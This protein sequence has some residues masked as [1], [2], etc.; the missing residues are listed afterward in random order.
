M[1]ISN[2]IISS[3]KQHGMGRGQLMNLANLQRNLQDPTQAKLRQLLQVG[4]CPLV[5]YI[6]I[7][8]VDGAG[9]CSIASYTDVPPLG[10]VVFLYV[11]DIENT[12]K[13]NEQDE[14]QW[15]SF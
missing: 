14:K 13:Y 3:S 6:L 9:D 4:C 7:A 12:I 10:I 1:S 11:L 5:K 15:S 2:S 8:L